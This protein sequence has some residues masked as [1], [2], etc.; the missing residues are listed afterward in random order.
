MKNVKL[1][2]VEASACGGRVHESV[3][4]GG[5]EEGS[6]HL[7]PHVARLTTPPASLA[8]TPQSQHLFY[9]STHLVLPTVLQLPRPPAAGVLSSVVTEPTLLNVRVHTTDVSST[10]PFDK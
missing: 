9:A 2:L 10:L 8:A 3:G 1:L 5:R 6:R 7:L 4:V